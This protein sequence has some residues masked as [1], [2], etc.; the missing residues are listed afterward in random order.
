MKAVTIF[1]LSV[2]FFSMQSLA[3]EKPS[4]CKNVNLSPFINSNL[5]PESAPEKVYKLAEIQNEVLESLE[6]SESTACYV[7]FY[8]KV[9]GESGDYWGERLAKSGCEL[10][11][12]GDISGNCPDREQA[13]K[14]L[15]QLNKLDGELREK[16]KLRLKESRKAR[17]QA[18]GDSGGDQQCGVD[19]RDPIAVLQEA[20]E[21]MCCGSKDDGGGVVR[22]VIKGTSYNACL[23]KIRPTDQKFF[24]GSGLADCLGN[25]VKAAAETL[26]QS[27]SSIVQLPGELWAARSQ[28][29]SL[30][31]NADARAQFTR[32]L[33]QQFKAFFSDRVDAFNMC[34]NEYEKA[35]YVCN[36][37]GRIVATAALPQTIGAF[38]G[39]ATKPVGT[40]ARAITQILEKTPEG[41]SILGELSKV[42]EAAAKGLQAA[43]A[44][45]KRAA[46]AA[47][48]LT[49][50]TASKTAK[51]AA[52]TG[53]AI[54]RPISLIAEKFAA[55][56][57]NSATFQKLF[58]TSFK[59]EKAA[60]G[61]ALQIVASNADDIPTGS[62]AVLQIESN[63]EISQL[64]PPVESPNLSAPEVALTA[65]QNIN[66]NASAGTKSNTNE[67]VTAKRHSPLILREDDPPRY[68]RE[69]ATSQ[70]R[71]SPLRPLPG[72]SLDAREEKLK[73]EIVSA[74]PIGYNEK[75]SKVQPQKVQFQDG[76]VGVWKPHE[77]VWHSNYRAE[78]LAYEI[79]RRLEIGI[80]PPTVE[81][82]YNG[83]KGSVQL[84]VESKRGAKPLESERDKQYFLD[85]IID[86]RDR[87]KD[88]FL[89]TEDGKIVSIDNAISFTGHG[90]NGRSLKSI[91][92][93]L[94]RFVETPEGQKIIENMRGALKDNEFQNTLVDYLGKGDARRTIERMQFMIQLADSTP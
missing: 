30:M 59:A 93:Q 2:L 61:Q 21:S 38:L 35:Q 92:P 46:D 22:A 85:Y 69:L 39:L 42:N 81:R 89:V 82:V 71:T 1:L 53:R 29:W 31:T 64:S 16:V 78:V 77:E 24:S 14:S 83:K 27:I 47:D 20:K 17:D 36:V 18:A 62:P 56:I 94:K 33:M 68:M 10:N 79:D 76:T 54:G 73:G 52:A 91:L 45:A 23:G 11:E 66:S 3:I 7:D 25:A 43:G 49:F 32:A 70:T 60:M 12:Q 6:S 4:S 63:R 50:G 15:D 87:H 88:N 57:E 84:F 58:V 28:I 13:Q 48:E 37:G 5:P 86:N 72:R 80:V 44:A 34:F 55:K 65:N 26:W 41:N 75:K 51:A 8:Q 67:T 9:I 74:S 40:A 19:S 90:Y